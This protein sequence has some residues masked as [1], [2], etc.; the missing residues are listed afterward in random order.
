[1]PSPWPERGYDYTKL[2]YKP[3]WQPVEDRR[4]ALEFC[5]AFPGDRDDELGFQTQLRREIPYLIPPGGGGSGAIPTVD[6]FVRHDRFGIRQDIDWELARMEKPELVKDKEKAEQ[7]G[8]AA[9]KWE[10]AMAAR[11]AQAPQPLP[12]PSSTQQ[13]ELSELSGTGKQGRP[14]DRVG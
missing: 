5:R 11:D 7:A 13:E 10:E 3:E 2:P 1:M 4:W 8:E 6:Y 12:T 9:K 14:E